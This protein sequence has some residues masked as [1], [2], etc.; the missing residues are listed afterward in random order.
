M[1]LDLSADHALFATDWP[2]AG[3]IALSSWVPPITDAYRL[4]DRIIEGGP[5]DAAYEQRA[6][7][8]HL[9]TLQAYTPA[10]GETITDAAGAVWVIQEVRQPDGGDYWGLPCLE[11]TVAGDV[12]TLWPAVDSQSAMG[13]KI[14]THP[15]AAAWFTGVAAKIMLRPSRA[16]TEVGQRDF[17]EIFDIYVQADVGQVHAGDILQDATGHQYTIVS[18]RNR[19]H[20]NALSVIECEDRLRGP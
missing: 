10:I 2:E 20:I 11:L 15:A 6:T 18:Y 1:A 14:T 9:S 3:A 19:A 12:V 16:E 4:E 8:F 7:E 13:S 17:V 5:T